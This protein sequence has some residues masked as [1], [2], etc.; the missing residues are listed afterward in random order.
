M[1]NVDGVAYIGAGCRWFTLQDA[2][3]HW[4]KREDRV[5]TRIIIE[6]AI[7]IAKHKGW[8]QGLET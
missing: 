5:L 3:K 6:S 7:A 2:I 1:A 4:E 8:A